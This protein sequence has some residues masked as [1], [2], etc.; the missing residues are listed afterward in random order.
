[1]AR[2]PDMPPRRNQKDALSFSPHV[3]RARDMVERVFNK[4]IKQCRRVAAR[5]NRLAANYLAFIQL[6]S[7]AYG[8]ALMKSALGENLRAGAHLRSL[9]SRRDA[10]DGATGHGPTLRRG[11]LKH[12]E[13]P[14]R[15][16]VVEAKNVKV[17]VAPLDLV[18]SVV[19]PVPSIDIFG[20]VDCPPT[21]TKAAQHVDAAVSGVALDVDPHGHTVLT[22]HR[23]VPDF[24]ATGQRR[25]LE[26]AGVTCRQPTPRFAGR[27]RRRSGCLGRRSRGIG[28][29]RPQTTLTAHPAR[30]DA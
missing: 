14:F 10:A 18:I 11:S 28:V 16:P 23:R 27:V 22:C 19:G 29:P 24:A 21:K 17:A 15:T 1:M 5:C 30:S 8:C 6:A 26:C 7:I 12:R 13:R 25:P 3:Y 4:K 20:D 2:G 9:I